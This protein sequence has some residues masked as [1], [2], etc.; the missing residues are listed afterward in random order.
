MSDTTTVPLAGLP[1]PTPKRPQPEAIAGN[2]KELL[3]WALEN[4]TDSGNVDRDKLMTH[5]EFKEMWKELCPD[6]VDQLRENLATLRSDSPTRDDIYLALDKILFIVEDIDAADWFVDLDG[7]ATVMPMIDHED[8]EVRGAAAWI[9]SNSLQ[10]NPKV[11]GKFFDKVGLAPLMESFER[12][13][14]EDP[15]KRKISAIS[16]AIRSFKP[17]RE[18]FYELDGIKRLEKKCAGSSMLCFR[19]CWTIS[20]ILDDEDADDTA[21]LRDS[22]VAEY[23]KAHAEEIGDEEVLSSVLARLA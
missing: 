13:T 18:Q 19:F 16:S 1:A 9:I 7:Y 23:L 15:L 3:R 17:L 21:R 6:T 22:G 2:E 5:E 10:N 20:V 12:E 14:A 4:S 8:T 11:Q